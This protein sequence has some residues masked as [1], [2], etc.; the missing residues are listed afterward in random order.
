MGSEGVQAAAMKLQ[1]LWRDA[2]EITYQTLGTVV[3]DRCLMTVNRPAI[4]GNIAL[5]GFSDPGGERGA[6]AFRRSGG[7]WHIVERV[8]RGYW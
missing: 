3:G 7:E 4:S 1:V 8:V 6:Y 2:P 5:V